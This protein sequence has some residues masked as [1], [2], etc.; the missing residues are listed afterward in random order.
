M[1]IQKLKAASYD[2]GETVPVKDFHRGAAVDVENLVLM[3]R[4]FVVAE[5][6]SNFA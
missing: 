1:K 6:Y 5:R 4:A 2:Q 3:P